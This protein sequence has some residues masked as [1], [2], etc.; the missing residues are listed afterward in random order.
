MTKVSE[1]KLAVLLKYLCDGDLAR[2]LNLQ[3]ARLT[4]YDLARKEAINH[5]STKKRRG[6][7]GCVTVWQGQRR[8]ERQGQG[9]GQR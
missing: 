5:L 3:S 8:Q 6:R 1:N 2:H 4:T 7:H 9:Q